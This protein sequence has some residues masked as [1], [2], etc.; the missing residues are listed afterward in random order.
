MAPANE[1]VNRAALLVDIKAVLYEIHRHDLADVSIGNAFEALLR[2]GSQNGVHNPGEFFLLTRAFVILESMIRQLSPGHNYMESFRE[3]ITRLKEQHFSLAR[4]K[5]KTTK[6][7]REMERLFSD[8]PSDTRRIL[9]RFA[10]GNLGRVQS[11]AL[12]ALGDRV[13]NNLERL[14]SSVAF[15]SLVV[16]GSLLLFAQM[17]GWHH[18]LGE[19]MVVSGI[20]G[21][22]VRSIGGWLRNRRRQ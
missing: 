8:A 13:S 17:G 14:S 6:L 3:E 15:A 7:A 11:P 4:I 21:M 5:D 10:E 12:E 1:Q 9:R 2:A 19:A 22:V 18:R 16:G 20:L